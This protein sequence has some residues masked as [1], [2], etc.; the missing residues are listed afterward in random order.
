MESV[1]AGRGWSRLGMVVGS[2][3]ECE[4]ERML[5]VGGGSVWMQLGHWVD[6][7]GFGKFGV[8]MLF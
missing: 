4:W 1:E 8:Q 5:Q 3:S 2:S 6:C 7:G